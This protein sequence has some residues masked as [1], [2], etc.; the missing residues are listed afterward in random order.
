MLYKNSFKVSII[1][2][3]CNQNLK[4][5]PTS[6]YDCQLSKHGTEI[7]G[8]IRKC[9]AFISYLIRKNRLTI[10]VYSCPAICPYVCT[11]ITTL[12]LVWQSFEKFCMNICVLFNFLLWDPNFWSKKCRYCVVTYLKN[13]QPYCSFVSRMW[14]KNIAVTCILYI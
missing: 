5:P 2:S 8:C 6:L 4:C 9:L 1:L 10:S 3:V 12:K 7:L 11:S 13:M 14:N